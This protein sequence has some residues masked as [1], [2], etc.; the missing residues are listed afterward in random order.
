VNCNR[1]ELTGIA[2]R[3]EALRY[4]PAGLPLLSFTVQHGSEQIE[5]GMQRKVECEVNVVA[6]GDLAIKSQGIKE[7]T[8]IKVAG[9]LAKRS[10]K[11]TQLVMHINTLEII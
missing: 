7:G 6:M 4:T 11:S 1:L 10:L 5:A 9:F 8:Q 3:I 2:V